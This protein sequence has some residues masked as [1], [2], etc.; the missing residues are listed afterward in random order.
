M[1]K[2]D[3]IKILVGSLNQAGMKVADYL[4]K[5]GYNVAQSDYNP[6]EIQLEVLK[7]KPDFLIISEITEFPY[8]LC[9]NLK[10]ACPKLKIIMLSDRKTN[11]GN[12]GLAKY[13]DMIIKSPLSCA[14]IK[15]ALRALQ[16]PDDSADLNITIT[17]SSDEGYTNG[18]I[19]SAI[20][21][22]MKRLCITPNY[23]GYGYIKE[24]IKMALTTDKAN[25]RVTKVIY[26]EIAAAHGVTT[27]SV[28]RNMRTAI[29]I[30]WEKAHDKDK[31]EIFGNFAIRPDH[32]PT[33]SEFIFVAAEYINSKYPAKRHYQ[34][35][36]NILA[37]VIY[38]SD[39]KKAVMPTG[40]AAFFYI[41]ETSCSK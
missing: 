37:K 36:L 25:R 10:G 6:L 17:R 35:P 41:N 7:S 14:D 26:P 8:E 28:E 22:V 5:Q 38:L 39:K 24:A 3:V 40:T 1:C 21:T 18:D 15:N 13:A 19:Q 4:K 34:P 32:Y 11:N 9:K 23:N 20:S 12:N 16:C 33:N 29:R 30:G 27:V 2:K 31:A